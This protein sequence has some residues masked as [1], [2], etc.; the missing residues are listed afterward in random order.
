M[1]EAFKPIPVTNQGTY[2]DRYGQSLNVG[3][4]VAWA[5]YD[6]VIAGYN[7]LWFTLAKKVVSWPNG[8]KTETAEIVEYAYDPSHLINTSKLLTPMQSIAVEQDFV[9]ILD[10]TPSENKKVARK[11]V[12]ALVGDYA[13]HSK[14]TVDSDINAL[15]IVITSVPGSTTDDWQ[16][17]HAYLRTE[18]DAK[19]ISYLCTSD[20]KF[21]DWYASKRVNQHFW[22]VVR[23]KASQYNSQ[24]LIRYDVPQNQYMLSKKRMQEYGLLEHLNTAMS[25]GEFNAI[26]KEDRAK[27]DLNG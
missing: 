17:F 5:G 4:P 18:Y 27:W 24:T 11:Y 23:I 3:D 25:V 9:K 12:V 16:R 22:D 2:T 14:D 7:N 10:H 21:H 15:Q 8:V 26:V 13:T 6:G 20:D 19:V 1:S